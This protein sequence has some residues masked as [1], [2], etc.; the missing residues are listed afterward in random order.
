MKAI[1]NYARNLARDDFKSEDI[2]QMLYEM[3]Q[4]TLKIESNISIKKLPF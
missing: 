1:A 3:W 2:V 4:T